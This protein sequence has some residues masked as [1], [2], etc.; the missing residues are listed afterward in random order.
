[1]N[2][3]IFRCIFILFFSLHLFFFPT[4]SVT[5]HTYKSSIRLF[6]V[7]FLFCTYSMHG[8]LA[9]PRT[10]LDT[11]KKNKKETRKSKTTKYT[12]R[13]HY[14]R[15]IDTKTNKRNR[16]KLYTNHTLF[17]LILFIH[18]YTYIYQR[19]TIFIALSFV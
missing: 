1:M 8:L 18:L 3:F 5:I 2:S 16:D 17:N 6:S 15:H 11:L 19:H 10:R 4:V 12:H 14:L 7:C 13:V 9:A